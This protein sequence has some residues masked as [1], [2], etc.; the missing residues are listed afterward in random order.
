MN[1]A[2]IHHFWTKIRPFSYWYFLAAFL[3]FGATAVL[4]LRANNMRAI[5]LRDE[6]IAVDE[7]DGDVETALKELRAFVHSHMNADLA[8]GSTSIQH[9]VQLKY[10]YERLTAA[11]KQRTDQANKNIYSAAQAH[12]EALFPASA[13]GGPR[14]PCIEQYVTEN[15]QEEQPIPD[16]LYKFNFVSPHWSPD[17]AGWSIVLAALFFVLFVFRFV[18]ERWIKFEL[19]SHL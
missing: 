1:K 16:S 18:L 17:L 12:C 4:A 10:R 7:K 15:S 3:F 9:P 13:S 2:T 11:E 19:H 5:E 14:I 6:V 8:G